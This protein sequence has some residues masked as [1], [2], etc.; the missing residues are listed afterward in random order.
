MSPSSLVAA[1]SSRIHV[2]LCRCSE[3]LNVEMNGY[4][5]KVNEVKDLPE[6][7]TKPEYVE[8]GLRAQKMTERRIRYL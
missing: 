2:E 6:R 7:L 4:N 1:A 3:N 5:R 8:V